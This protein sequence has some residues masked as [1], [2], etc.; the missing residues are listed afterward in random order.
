MAKAER[1]LA[2]L[3]LPLPRESTVG[4]FF[5]VAFGVDWAA[6]GATSATCAPTLA[7]TSSST[8]VVVPTRYVLRSEA[9]FDIDEREHDL[10]P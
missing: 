3:C 1:V 8:A 9:T 4:A 7:T 10:S 6:L 5:P 2:S